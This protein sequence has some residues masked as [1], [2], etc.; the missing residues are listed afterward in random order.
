[1]LRS[2]RVRNYA[3]IEST[4]VE[5]SSGLTALTGETGA[6][7]SILVGALSLALGERALPEAVRSGESTAR[8][9]CLFELSSQHPAL[10]I[11]RDLGVPLSGNEVLM[12]REVSTS[13]RS[14]AFLNDSSATL[15]T[16]KSLG[17]T[18]VDLVGQHEHQSLLH[19]ERHLDYL[20]GFAGLLGPEREDFGLR[21]RDHLKTDEE[22]SALKKAEVL[23]GERRELYAFQVRELEEARL[24][25]GEEE[26]LV[27][28]GQ[29]LEN[30][31]RLM[32]AS[33]QVVEALVDGEDAVRSRIDAARKVL[34][35][36]AGVDGRLAEDLEGLATLS[37]QVEDIASALRRY[38]EKLEFSPDRLDE[39][40]E[41]LDAIWR[42]KKK[43]GGSVEA[44]REHLEAL[45]GELGSQES[46]AGDI[47]RLEES[48]SRSRKA[49]QEGAQALSKKRQKAAR[50]LALLVRK[51]LDGLGLEKS[52]FEVRILQEPAPDGLLELG[53]EKVRV[54]ETGW[55]RARFFF[56]ANPGEELRPLDRVASGGEISR[57]MLALRTVLAEVDR[58]P[59]LVF[60]EIDTGIGGKVAEAVGE[61]LKGIARKRQVLCI[62][63]LPQI[64]SQGDEHLVVE[65]RERGGRTFVSV[66]KLTHAER[67]QELAR[68]MAGKE[69][70]DL[71]RAHARE[72]LKPVLQSGKKR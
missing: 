17:D 36:S 29:V 18:L 47:Q 56:S 42:L 37:Y 26:A 32:L 39:I 6:G 63:H 43:Y 16:L 14:R 41:R 58:V 44:A 61:R 1:M 19:E 13:G 62:T 52:Q 7:K 9:E 50:E 30:T 3:I 53:G 72:M 20:D 5:F 67:V 4:E 54:S 57:L 55:D 70:T 28:E 11:L 8:V 38:R 45:R 65:K 69:V 24:V 23:S 40:R 31:E 33:G 60:D 49:L 48:L 59:T 15:A 51:E 21:L 71:A 66:R 46:R 12:K 35:D 68:M 22:L 25:P 64:A 27:N 2:L 34:E 10:G